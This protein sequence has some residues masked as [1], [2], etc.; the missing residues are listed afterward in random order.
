[1]SLAA[2]A[3]AV[4]QIMRFKEGLSLVTAVLAARIGLHDHLAF[5][6]ASPPRYQ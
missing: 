1:M 6:F 3:H 4:L 5:M 2:P